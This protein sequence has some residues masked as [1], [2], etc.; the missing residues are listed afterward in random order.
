MTVF[1]FHP[2]KTITTGEGG[3]ITT[4]EGTLYERLVML[5][6]HGNVRDPAK[7]RCS[8]EGPWYYEM[9]ALGYNYRLSDIQA[10]LGLSQLSRLARFVARR[11]EI[12]R[13][14]REELS[15]LKA[16]SLLSAATDS[17]SAYHLFPILVDF[18]RLSI[19]KAQMFELLAQEGLHL[20]VHYI[21]VHLQPYY[22]SLGFGPGMFPRAEAYYAKAISLPLYP[23]L[24]NREV[25]K[26]AQVVRR[27]VERNYA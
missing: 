14:Y 27:I 23:S 26:V 8:G 20:Q 4:N 18:S 1:S 2:V 17:H 6:N 15:S 25:R 3:A 7:L 12:V 11:R 16:C 10:A 22:R 19:T 9:Q 5:R 21:P 13:L 24:S